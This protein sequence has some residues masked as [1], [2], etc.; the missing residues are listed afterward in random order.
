MGLE[1]ENMGTISFAVKLSGEIRKR[2]NSP[3]SRYMASGQTLKK[4]S[5][6]QND[7][8]RDGNSLSLP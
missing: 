4:K 5:S 2:A 8:R 1:V 3:G 7:E 6:R